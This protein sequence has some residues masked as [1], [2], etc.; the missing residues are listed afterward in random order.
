MSY[1]N[2]ARCT[3]TTVLVEVLIV[4]ALLCRGTHAVEAVVDAG[5]ATAIPDADTNHNAL[6]WTLGAHTSPRHIDAGAEADPTGKTYSQVSVAEFEEAIKPAWS[7]AS[8]EERQ[9][10]L[11]EWCVRLCVSRACPRP[12][13]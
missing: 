4:A 13:S 10:A 2:L 11:V 1:S 5:G 9:A 12:S 8:L 6:P 3:T 7:Q